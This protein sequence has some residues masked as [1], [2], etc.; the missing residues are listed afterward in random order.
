MSTINETVTTA[1]ANN[2]L[3]QYERQAAPVVQALV[4]REQAIAA[5]LIQAAVDNG[6]DRDQAV[7]VFEGAG[8]A[9]PQGQNAVGGDDLGS[10]RASVDSLVAFARRHG[11]NG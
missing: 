1:L 4:Q 10:I 11:F 5:T 9:L 6:I 8:L 3:R 7:R 2:G